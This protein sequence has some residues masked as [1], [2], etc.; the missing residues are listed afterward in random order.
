MKIVERLKLKNYLILLDS[1]PTPLLVLDSQHK[2]VARNCSFTR[3]FNKNGVINKPANLVFSILR[4]DVIA[5]GVR[6]TFRVDDSYYYF[7]ITSI[8]VEDFQGFLVYIVDRTEIH[9]EMNEK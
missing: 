3:H 7:V 2:V 9:K 1:V 4:E 5:D 8:E 6:L